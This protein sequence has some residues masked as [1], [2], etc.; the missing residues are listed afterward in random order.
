MT[1][2]RRRQNVV[3]DKHGALNVVLN[4]NLVSF[5][6][7]LL[8]SF[9]R[10]YAPYIKKMRFLAAYV[11]PNVYGKGKEKIQKGRKSN[12]GWMQRRKFGCQ[13]RRA[14]SW[15]ELLNVCFQ[16]CSIRTT[17]PHL[18]HFLM[19]IFWLVLSSG[20]WRWSLAQTDIRM[21][22]LLRGLSLFNV[23]DELPACR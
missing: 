10:F 19:H 1:V 22:R 16:W 8:S 4:L 20:N 5:P 11:S 14:W 6:I 17:Q 12:G 7:N 21:W 9:A 13:T 2:R 15:A 18:S 23:Q 3:S